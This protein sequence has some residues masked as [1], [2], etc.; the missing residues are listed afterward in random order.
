MEYRTIIPHIKEYLLQSPQFEF[1]GQVEIIF[2]TQTEEFYHYLL[3]DVASPPYLLKVRAAKPVTPDPLERDFRVLRHLEGCEF[4]PQAYYYDPNPRGLDYSLMLTEYV[5]G[6]ALDYPR[7]YLKVAQTLG[8]IHSHGKM[9]LPIVSDPIERA[10]AQAKLNLKDALPS[11]VFHMD[12][13]YFFDGFME[14]AEEHAP[15]KV[16]LFDES[17]HTL[18]HGT[19]DTGDFVV[20]K[21]LILQNWQRAYIGDPAIALAKFLAR[22]TTLWSSRLVLRAIDREDFYYR[23]EKA[24]GLEKSTIRERIAAYMPY[25]LLEVFSRFAKYYYDHSL[26][27]KDPGDPL[28]MKQL[29]TYLEVDFMRQALTEFIG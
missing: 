16:H 23:Y 15:K 5:G 29:Q 17:L 2:L 18:N 22:T 25:H 6:E 24:L 20:G 4:T 13:L 19:L 21:R 9:D 3:K 26:P 12:H 14:W 11:G 8:V 1:K 7:D 28:V 10:V 27:G